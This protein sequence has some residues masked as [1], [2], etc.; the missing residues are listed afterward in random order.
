[1]HR[2]R[3]EESS[4]ISTSPLPSTTDEAQQE[5]LTV[6]AKGSQALTQCETVRAA[7]EEGLPFPGHS[8]QHKTLRQIS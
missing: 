5:G 3:G 8:V 2:G 4:L 7:T 1:M 6:H